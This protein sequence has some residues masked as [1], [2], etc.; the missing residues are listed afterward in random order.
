MWNTDGPRQGARSVFGPFIAEN[1]AD[2]EPAPQ[3]LPVRT[4]TPEHDP[5]NTGYVLAMTDI[6]IARLLTTD[7]VAEILQVS[8]R[9]L[10]AW[11]ITGDGPACIKVGKHTR[12]READVA[13]WINAQTPIAPTASKGAA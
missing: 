3:V 7:E 5:V 10:E 8:K 11:R 1:E 13:D 2:R 6:T 12:Y 4:S 9:T